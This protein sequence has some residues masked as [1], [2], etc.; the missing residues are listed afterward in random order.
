MQ[1]STPECSLRSRSVR[2]AGVASA[3]RALH[4]AWLGRSRE[5][6]PDNADLQPWSERETACQPTVPYARGAPP[7]LSIVAFQLL[8]DEGFLVQVQ[9]DSLRAPVPLQLVQSLLSHALR[10][11]LQRDM[12]C[13]T[14][15]HGTGST[16][17]EMAA[18]CLS[19]PRRSSTRSE[20]L[21]DPRGIT[22]PYGRRVIRSTALRW[23]TCGR[24][25]ARGGDRQQHR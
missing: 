6:S 4:R 22:G 12:S 24:H 16:P 8:D 17:T 9:G 20:R 2:A 21:V 10:S 19:Q 1:H 18:M 25:A 15:A 13:K 11:H 23:V 14:C 3:C 7:R 5:K